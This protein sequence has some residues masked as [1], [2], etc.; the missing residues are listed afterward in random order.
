MANLNSVTYL[1]GGISPVE[2][3]KEKS[4]VLTQTQPHPSRSDRYSLIETGKVI[5]QLQGAGFVGKLIQEERSRKYKGYGTHLVAFDHP[6]IRFKNQGIDKEV[7]PR[8]LFRNSYHGRTTASA[9]FG[10]FRLVCK[11]GLMMLTQVSQ[12]FQLKHIDLKP[13]EIDALVASMKTGFNS[14]VV[15]KI[16]RLMETE[17]TENQQI[18]F[19]R[20][21]MN[22]RFR[23]N[24]SYQGGD[25][26]KLLTVT[27]PEDKGD[28][29]W[30]V[31]NRVQENIG[32]NFRES[33][34]EVKYSLRGSDENGNSVLKERTVSKLTN[35]QEVMY[36]NDFLLNKAL[37]V[38]PANSSIIQVA[39]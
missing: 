31:L 35:I 13:T 2:T 1:M 19:A 20:L 26:L 27:R 4:L 6:D 11:N 12:S 21:A 22:E 25:Y 17:W 18:E 3:Q 38:N 33:P 36:L 14:E 30:A 5:E 9:F 15:E 7:Q 29:G 10:L 28:S 37:T 23:A 39:A 32:L 34:I 8:L 16:Q 24:P